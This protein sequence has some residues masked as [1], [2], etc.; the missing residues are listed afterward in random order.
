MFC[1]NLLN[2]ESNC[3]HEQALR[4]D[5]RSDFDTMLLR[6]NVVSIHIGNLQLLMT[7]VYDPSFM[8]EIFVGKHIYGLSSCRNLLL[9][10]AC[11]RYYGLEMTL[12]MGSRS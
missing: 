11:T 5:M 4:I 6:D 2:N 3:V 1:D 9:P 7:E 10:Q 8:K 12:F